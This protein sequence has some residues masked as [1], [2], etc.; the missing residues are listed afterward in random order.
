MSTLDRVLQLQSQGMQEADIIRILREEN[1]SP[2]DINDALNQ[3]KV[4]AAV[5]GTIPDIN[6]SNQFSDMEQSIM[7]P[8]DMS[9]ASA[10][11]EIAP[12]EAYSA[13][14]QS[15]PNQQ[16]YAPSSGFDTETISEIAEQIVIEK[17]EEFTQRTGDLV[18]F[19]SEVQDKL[20]DFNERIKRIE[21]TIDKLQ[22]AIIGKI[23]EYGDNLN[24]VK[25]DMNS[26]HETM[27]KM[28]NPLIDSYM[29]MKKLNQSREEKSQESRQ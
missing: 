26:L 15:Y 17:L 22:Q 1:I 5:S 16:Y 10:P 18:S 13:P 19:K 25:K 12:A 8:E 23:G 7:Q 20:K 27:S 9:Q 2:L 4:K 28:M 24:F 14:E 11:A 6:P 21:T 3:A 29:E